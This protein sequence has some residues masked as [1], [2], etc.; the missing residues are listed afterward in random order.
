MR[1]FCYTKLFEVF[2]HITLGIVF[3]RV[4]KYAL[5]ELELLMLDRMF[6]LE[7]HSQDALRRSGQGVL[8]G[9]SE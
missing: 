7:I 4:S 6:Y 9:V 8:E 3:S 1:L 5:T 2:G